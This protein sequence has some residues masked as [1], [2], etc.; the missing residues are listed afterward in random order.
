LAIS[1][2]GKSRNSVPKEA[3][4]DD[5]EANPMKFLPSV[6]KQQTF[7]IPLSAWLL[8]NLPHLH[9]YFQDVAVQIRTPQSVVSSLAA[10]NFSF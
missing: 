2:I 7:V 1:T 5:N 9:K 3:E 4:D 10:M 6:N 8:T